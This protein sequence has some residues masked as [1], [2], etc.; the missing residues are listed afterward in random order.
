M[1]GRAG[2]D[3]LSAD[4]PPPAVVD[5]AEPLLNAWWP[6]RPA[7]AAVVAQS[8]ERLRFLAMHRRDWIEIAK[9]ERS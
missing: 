3:K 7:A 8:V 9:R 2:L 6:D 1:A 4:V 5:V